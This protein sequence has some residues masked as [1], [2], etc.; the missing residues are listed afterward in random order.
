MTNRKKFIAKISA[1]AILLF[2]L[3]LFP[4]GKA[5]AQVVNFC[6][7]SASYQLDGPFDEPEPYSGYYARNPGAVIAQYKTL[8]GRYMIAQ[9]TCNGT[10]FRNIKFYSTAGYDEFADWI[11]LPDSTIVNN[12]PNS[13][14]SGPFQPYFSNLHFG[15]INDGVYSGKVYLYRTGATPL[16][17]TFLDSNSSPNIR[18]PLFD[19]QYNLDVGFHLIFD[20]SCDG[21]ATWETDQIFP[22]TTDIHTGFAITGRNLFSPPDG[23]YYHQSV[24]SSTQTVTWTGCGGT[25]RLDTCPGCSNPPG[26]PYTPPTV[27]LMVRKAATGS[28]TNGPLALNSG[29]GADLQWTSTNAS[30]N[31]CSAGWTALTSTS[32]TQTIAPIT[33]GSYTY[34][35]TCVGPGGTATDTVVVD[36]S[37][38]PDLIPLNPPNAPVIISGTTNLDG[39]YVPGTPITFQVSP[40]NI[41]GSFLGPTFNVKLQSKINGS[42]DAFADLAETASVSGGLLSGASKNASISHTWSTSGTSYDVRYC[43]DMP[44]NTG[45]GTIQE[46]NETN[47]CS[48]AITKVSVK[49]M[50]LVGSCNKVTTTN[51]PGLGESVTWQASGV[52]GGKLPYT[53]W[54]SGTDQATP[55][56]A[57]PYIKTY[58]TF[59]VKTPTLTVNSAD[60]QSINPVCQSVTVSPSL[61]VV[62][63]GTGTINSVANFNTGTESPDGKI[64]GC[65]NAG[66]S[67]CTGQYVPNANAGLRATIPPSSTI[68]WTGCDSL[69]NGAGGSG[70]SVVMSGNRTVTATFTVPITAIDVT[71]S[72]P[73][74][75]AYNTGPALSWNTSGSPTSC[76]ASVGW[77][78]SK[79]TNATNGPQAQSAITTDTTYTITCDKAGTASV[80]KSCVVEVAPTRPIISVAT[81]YCGGRTVVSLPTPSQGAASYNLHRFSG[82]W[83]QIET[84][85]TAASFPYENKR[86]STGVSY[87]YQLEAVGASGHSTFSDYNL[88]ASAAVSSLPCVVNLKVM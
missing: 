84:G 35:I 88:P 24:D 36:A 38:L 82:S 67:A 73:A 44:P 80:S 81:G 37:A 55:L 6:G 7:T 60:G 30:P 21:G 71:L 39:S 2:G 25:A 31:G 83:S 1:A 49:Y 77:T 59:G 12:P 63:V 14:D 28:Y 22:P 20:Y 33:T 72:C 17:E 78:G 41:G 11:R 43:V 27:N 23:N 70:C 52:S 15:L 40:K 26:N 50:P 74:S 86:L 69:P 75:V 16:F 34:T 79:T 76:T 46:S 56:N 13:D 87:R 51:T 64:S 10:S 3:A 57:N 66:G 32:G 65:G 54:W 8:K 45:Y 61:T 53:Y 42:A 4:A 5:D 62:V 58:N 9:G 19:G 18:L 68:S 47:N 29:D 48:G 85:L